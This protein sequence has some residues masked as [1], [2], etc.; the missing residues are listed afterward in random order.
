M[1]VKDDKYRAT[2]SSLVSPRPIVV[3][4]ATQSRAHARQ[5]S[6]KAPR[7][8]ASPPS[9]IHLDA[10][11]GRPHSEPLTRP[12]LVISPFAGR[13][14]LQAHHR[15]IEHDGAG[16]PRTRPKAVFALETRQPG[17]REAGLAHCARVRGRRGEMCRAGIS[18]GELRERRAG[19]LFA[20]VPAETRSCLDCP[21]VSTT[22]FAS[23][24]LLRLRPLLQIL[25]WKTVETSASS[26][27]RESFLS[28]REHL[29]RRRLRSRIGLAI[30][31]SNAMSAQTKAGRTER[32]WAR[33][34]TTRVRRVRRLAK[35]STGQPVRKGAGLRG[36]SPGES[37]QGVSGCAWLTAALRLSGSSGH[38]AGH[39]RLARC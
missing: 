9:A 19:I 22:S 38:S 37:M 5:Q 18:A 27:S 7:P 30:S 10:H 2:A 1:K 39:R 35:I 12:R 31:G 16:V 14:G 11:P 20:S 15:R 21:N 36:G 8:A 29:P 17:R 24:S 6:P 13:L 26:Q 28:R 25:H 33:K 34:R 3:T 32:T 23:R 4:R